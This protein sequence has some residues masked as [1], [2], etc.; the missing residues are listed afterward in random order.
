MNVSELED[1]LFAQI[2]AVGLPTPVR[3]HKP[4]AGRYYRFDF[5]WLKQK[6]AVEVEGGVWSRGRHTRGAGFTEDCKKYN[7][8]TA[9]GWRVFRFTGNMVE[10]GY[11]INLLKEIFRLEKEKEAK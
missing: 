10:S 5:A 9:G 1:L 11:A 3:E 6:I 4:I 8:A 7:L 2:Q